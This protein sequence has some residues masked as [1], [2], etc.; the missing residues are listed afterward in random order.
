MCIR[1]RASVI[2]F[3]PVCFLQF[4]KEIFCRP[5]IVLFNLRSAVQKR[6]FYYTPVQAECH[7]I[8]LRG[9]HLV[10]CSYHQCRPVTADAQAEI[11]R[12]HV[13]Q[14]HPVDFRKQLVGC[15]GDIGVPG[16]GCCRHPDLTEILVVPPV[17][18]P[19][20]HLHERIIHLGIPIEVTD[21]QP[22]QSQ[23]A[24]EAQTAYCNEAQP[25]V[26]FIIIQ[27]FGCIASIDGSN[28]HRGH[29]CVQSF[30]NVRPLKLDFDN[31]PYAEK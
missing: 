12:G 5:Q 29:S 22:F 9:T 1:D 16:H 26:I 6:R 21:A 23:A 27:I 14:L 13:E 15:L 30:L 10:S 19:A 2:F 3:V 25:V 17:S 31:L 18:K 20:P 28:F 24:G 11:V 7:R 8:V 4:R